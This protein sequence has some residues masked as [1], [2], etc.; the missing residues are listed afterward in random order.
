MKFRSGSR[1]PRPEERRLG[2]GQPAKAEIMS[3]MYHVLQSSK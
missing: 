1:G 3:R 2:G